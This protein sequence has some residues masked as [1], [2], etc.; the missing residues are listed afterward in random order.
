MKINKL[1]IS[2]EKT[3]KPLCEDYLSL[4]LVR[5]MDC[6]T[7]WNRKHQLLKYLPYLGFKLNKIMGRA[8]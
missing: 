6:I 5:A 8:A 2:T 3:L 7:A 4:N 1:Q